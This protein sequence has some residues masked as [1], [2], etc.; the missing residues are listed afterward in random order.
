MWAGCNVIDLIQGR[1]SLRKLIEEYGV[2]G[3][4]VEV[5]IVWDKEHL[6]T[7]TIGWYLYAISTT[8]KER[9][10]VLPPACRMVAT[11]MQPTSKRIAHTET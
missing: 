10:V 3:M 5:G 8:R 7:W 9:D 1:L 4:I 11:W 2:L 6:W